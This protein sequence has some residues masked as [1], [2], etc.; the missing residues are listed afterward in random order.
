M[1]S[2][3]ISIIVPVYKAEKYLLQCLDSILSQSY[4]EWECILV[5]DGSPDCSGEICDD[6]ATKDFRF[7]V[8]HQPNSGASTARNNGI[9][10]AQGE[11][12]AFVDA[13]DVIKPNYLLNMITAVE[14]HNVDFV[15]GG[16]QY[17]QFDTGLRSDKLYTPHNYIGSTISEVYTRDHI[18]QNGAPYSKLYKRSIINEYDIR[19]SPVMHYAEDC[20]FMMTYLN[21]VSRIVFIDSL[22]YIYRLLPTS[23]SHQKMNLESEKETLSEM[24]K[25]VDEIRNRYPEADL[26]DLQESLLQYYGRVATA[27]STNSLSIIDTYREIHN[28]SVQCRSR[29]RTCDFQSYQPYCTHERIIISLLC[30]GLNA[31]LLLYIKM[32]YPMIN[33]IS[34]QNRKK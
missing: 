3:K 12:I 8:I 24:T 33:L 11:W 23:L 17:W 13:D 26:V 21:Y 14:I 7:K 4:K 19:F 27:I 22:D 31:M 9:A 28:L 25:R 18:Y 16:L 20:N 29:F 2:P 15:I 34:P 30:R 1:P 6:Y 5:D 32:I 10:S